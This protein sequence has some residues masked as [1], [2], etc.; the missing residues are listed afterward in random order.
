MGSL[1]MS[2]LYPS[3][4]PEQ[5]L[6]CL[7]SGCGETVVIITIDITV[8]LCSKALRQLDPDEPKLSLMFRPLSSPV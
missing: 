2:L 1:G 3:V 5:A 6:I 8:T 4:G 7:L